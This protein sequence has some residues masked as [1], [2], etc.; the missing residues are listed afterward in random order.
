MTLACNR[1][2]LGEPCNVVSEQNTNSAKLIWYAKSVKRRYFINHYIQL[3][4]CIHQNIFKSI[5]NVE[6][7]SHQSMMKCATSAT[8]LKSRHV[9][10]RKQNAK[11]TRIQSKQPLIY[12]ILKLLCFFPVVS[13]H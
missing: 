1:G 11:N 3:K 8:D 2:S 13:F 7:F 5:H 4:A 12:K 9:E 10:E 6:T